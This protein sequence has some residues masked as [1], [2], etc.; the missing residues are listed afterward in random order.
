M[1]NHL[2][3]SIWDIPWFTIPVL[4]AFLGGL[5]FMFL[6][7]YRAEILMLNAWRMEPLNAFF[8]FWTKMG[9]TYPYLVALFLCLFWRF[10]YALLI[11]MAGIL[12][13]PYAYFLKDWIG[14]MRPLNWLG[15]QGLRDKLV[16]VPYVELASGYTSFPSGHT[17]AAFTLYTLLALM[18]PKSRAFWGLFFAIM[19]VLVG[20]SRVF[21]AQHFV[22]D[23]L[24]G[25]V[26]GLLL[27][28]VVWQIGQTAAFR[29]NTGLDRNLF[30]LTKKQS[31][32]PPGIE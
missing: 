10:R 19:A 3:R 26:F 23:V 1:Q 17:I 31:S 16:V 5:L 15:E 30:Q 13:L 18:V 20:I 6:V 2:N 11:G 8:W 32:A 14:V 22:A 29:T 27:A 24:G 25:V 7:P 4:L 12:V 21:L 28:S 9:E